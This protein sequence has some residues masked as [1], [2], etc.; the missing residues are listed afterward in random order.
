MESALRVTAPIGSWAVAGTV[1]T[2]I[3]AK[4]AIASSFIGLESSSWWRKHNA[5]PPDPQAPNTD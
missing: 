1:A 5:N 4:K 3:P 2:I